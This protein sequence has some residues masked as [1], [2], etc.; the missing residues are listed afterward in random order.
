MTTGPTPAILLR[1][2]SS[3][4]RAPGLHPG[5]DRFDPDAVHKNTSFLNIKWCESANLDQ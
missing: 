4:G 1:A 5:G 3:F 2:A